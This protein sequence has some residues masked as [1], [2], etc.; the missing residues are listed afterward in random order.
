[1]N[2]LKR[3]LSLCFCFFP[4]FLANGSQQVIIND[5]DWPPYFM[6]DS[7][8]TGSGLAKEIINLCIKRIG[9]RIEYRQLPIKRTHHFME[10]GKLDITVY[11]YKEKREE[12]LYYA[13]EPLFN[14]EYGFMV[15]ADSNIEINSLADLKPYTMG[16]LAG[17]TYT[18]K[19]KKII[20]DKINKNEVVTGY[21]LKAMFAQLLADIPRFEIMADSK[22][23]FYWEAKKLGVT[24]KIKV[25][26]Y[27]IKNKTYYITVSKRSKNIKAPKAFLAETD[28]CLRSI[29]ANGEYQSILARYGIY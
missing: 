25:L 15:K 13:K 11:S 6:I 10:A 29:K 28:K 2:K 19:L 14:S 23:T 24:D 5:I 20:D 21:T 26:D 27:N 22:N 17:L 7:Q 1:M 16:H 9:Q 18:P 4:L 3:K 12:I 8:Y